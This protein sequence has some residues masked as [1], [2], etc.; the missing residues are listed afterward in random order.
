MAPPTRPSIEETVDSAAVATLLLRREVAEV[1]R[2]L[3]ELTEQNRGRVFP[4]ILALLRD[5]AR[6]AAT[7]APKL[8]APQS[9]GLA[10]LLV[11]STVALP[12]ATAGFFL[13]SRDPGA[14]L[15]FV[16]AVLHASPS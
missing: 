3:D 5:L 16:A 8:S 11:A 12:L 4:Q 10:T 2:A 9:F 6:L 13:A 14:L 7:T 15:A 1:R